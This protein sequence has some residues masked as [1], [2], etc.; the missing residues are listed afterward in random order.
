MSGAHT[1]RTKES[2]RMYE[3]AQRL[4]RKM[5]GRCK[6]V[7]PLDIFA[8]GR[9]YKDGRYR[10]SYCRPCHATY[11]YIA[12]LKT[13]YGITPEQYNEM[14]RKQ[15]GV[16]AICLRPSRKK[17]LAVDHVHLPDKKIGRIRGLLCVFCNHRFLG[18]GRENADWHER[19]AIY[20]RSDFDGRTYE[21]TTP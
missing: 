21:S 2:K 17:R 5:C 4:G 19:A 20:L 11:Q 6:E 7:K 10:Y 3:S 8:P 9:K 1:A 18:R 16:C 14:F 12:A 15:K 13:K